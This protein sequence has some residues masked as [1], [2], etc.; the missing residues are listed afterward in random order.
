MKEIEERSGEKD[1]EAEA[2]TL[3]QK[4]GEIEGKIA[5][6]KKENGLD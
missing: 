3:R 1:R 5:A 4:L 6:L 2:G